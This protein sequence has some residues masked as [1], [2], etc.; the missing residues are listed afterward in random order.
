MERHADDPAARTVLLVEDNPTD[1]FVI[2]EVLGSCGVRLNLRIARDG[3]EALQYLQDLA[4]DENAECPALVLLDLNLPRVPGIEVLRELRGASRCPQT[5]VVVVTSSLAESDRISAQELGAEAY[6]Q[7]PT[8]LTL[9][10]QLGTLIKDV[11]ER[12][13]KPRN[14]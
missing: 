13:E 8:D 4:H 2:K 1:I 11:L 7:K 9:Y 12:D 5:P 3:Q 14:P 10:L 6:F